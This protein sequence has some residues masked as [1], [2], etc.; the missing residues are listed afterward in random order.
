M[1]V[2]MLVMTS[3]SK[4][5]HKDSTQIDIRGKMCPLTF[6]YTK[7]TLEELEK[8]DILEV[9]LDFPPALKNIPESCKRQNLAELLEVIE[10]PSDKP[11]WIMILKKL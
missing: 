5:I 7:L 4:S 10:N 1:G 9:Y 3:R 6:V 2:W 11:E 8:G